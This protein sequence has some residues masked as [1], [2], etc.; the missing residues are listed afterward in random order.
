[1]ALRTLAD[2]SID[3]MIDSGLLV[4]FP[5]PAS[6]TGE[7]VAELHVHGGPA[8]VTALLRCLARQPGLRLAGAGEFSRRAFDNGKLDLAQAEG[9]ADLIAAETET[10]RRLAL[11]QTSGRLGQYV[12]GW[13]A[14]LTAAMANVEAGLDFADESDVVAEIAVERLHAVAHE[15]AEILGGAR[16]GE[17]LRDGLT[18]AVAGAPN[19]GKSSLI[20]ALVNR[21]VSIVS[22]YAGTTRDV[23]EVPLNLN[24]VAAVLIDTAG[25]RDTTDPV[26]AE[27]VRRARL[28]AAEADLVLHVAEIPPEQPLGWVVLNKIDRSGANPG[29]YEDRVH[30]SAR[31]GAG[32][33]ALADR[34]ADW[35]GRHA[36]F[37]EYP[38]ISR[39]RQRT[40]LEAAQRHLLAAT[41]ETDP[42][43]HAEALRLA[44]RA[45]AALIGQI[46]VEDV[47]DDIFR[48]F[49][50]GK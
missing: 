6:F 49:C 41:S 48:Q 30:V 43:L 2:P 47:L 12:S 40:A 27:G 19:A 20:N 50:I 45:L 34:L 28:R 11:G 1:M 7:D 35:A 24:G 37:A 22:E 25:L 10:Q 13:R 39:E 38:L 29:Y 8:V 36:D 44:S 21:E 3:L 33:D 31:T 14:E 42:V 32:I 17:R 46:G 16:L 18:V 26:E 23:I 9:L 4:I 5:G 15:V